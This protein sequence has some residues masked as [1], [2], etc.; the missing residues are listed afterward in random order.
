MN[1]QA[2][3]Y[4]IFV[5]FVM[6]RP[7]V[8]LVINALPCLSRPHLLAATALWG[9]IAILQAASLFVRQERMESCLLESQPP[10][11]VRLVRRD[12][13]AWQVQSLEPE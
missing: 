2:V 8:H 3:N 13:T 9:G 1:R 11:L 10:V 5:I 7:Q 4:L 12:L 6:F